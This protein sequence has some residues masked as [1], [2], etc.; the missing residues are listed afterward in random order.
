MVLSDGKYEFKMQGDTLVCLRYGEEWRDFIGDNAVLA[1]FRHAEEL[2]DA[3]EKA[4]LEYQEL[5]ERR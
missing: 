1:L 3:N 5:N 4:R 2:E